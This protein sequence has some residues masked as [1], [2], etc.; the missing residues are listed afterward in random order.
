[1]KMTMVNPGLKGLI[2][3]LKETYPEQIG[4]EAREPEVGLGQ[5]GAVL[6]DEV[7]VVHVGDEV[8]Q[9]DHHQ[10]GMRL[11]KLVVSHAVVHLQG[12]EVVEQSQ[13]LRLFPEHSAI[14]KTMFSINYRLVKL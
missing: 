14:I 4:R 3:A 12:L 10:A 2:I 8:V 9:G 13:Q 7:R 5:L 6:P 1:M 11:Q